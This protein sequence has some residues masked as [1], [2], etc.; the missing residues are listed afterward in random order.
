MKIE[1][2]KFFFSTL[3]LTCNIRQSR[4]FH[5]KTPLNLSCTKIWKVLSCNII[6][7]TLCTS[8]CTWTMPCKILFFEFLCCVT[9]QCVI[10]YII[11]WSPVHLQIKTTR[12]TCVYLNKKEWFFQMKIKWSFKIIT[13][14]KSWLA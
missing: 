2:N 13:N 7:H 5:L 11:E 14:K 9:L 4:K 3:Q 8:F 10:C 1:W 12:S 6:F